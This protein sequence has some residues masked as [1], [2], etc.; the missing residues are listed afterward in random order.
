MLLQSSCSCRPHA[1]RAE[2]THEPSYD[3]ESV[4]SSLDASIVPALAYHFAFRQV[5]LRLV[6]VHASVI[7]GI[8]MTTGNLWCSTV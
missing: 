7:T 2:S 1:S 6:Q 4:Q 5:L 3:H 8:M